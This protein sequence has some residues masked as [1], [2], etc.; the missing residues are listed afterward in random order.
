MSKCVNETAKIFLENLGCFADNDED[1]DMKE[2][3]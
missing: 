2:Y 3:V 1:F